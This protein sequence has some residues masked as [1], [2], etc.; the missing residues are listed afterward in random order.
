[1]LYALQYHYTYGMMFCQDSLTDQKREIAVIF[2]VRGL[3]QTKEKRLKR[4][5]KWLK[6][7]SNGRFM[8]KG[9]LSWSCPQEF[10]DVYPLQKFIV[11]CSLSI[12]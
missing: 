6:T 9:G 5:Y 1:M 2:A 8:P 12:M 4:G 3:F 10:V 7:F 11:C